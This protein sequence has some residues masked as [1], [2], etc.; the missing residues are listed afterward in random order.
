MSVTAGGGSREGYAVFISYRRR[1]VPSAAVAR[2]LR[3]LLKERGVRTYFDTEEN[4]PGDE[5]SSLIDSVATSPSLRVGVVVIEQ[6]WVAT[7]GQA[8]PE[9]EDIVLREVEHFLQRRAGPEPFVI[10]PIY[11]RKPRLDPGDFPAPP[12]DGSDRVRAVYD[13]LYEIQ[14]LQANA[15]DHHA[16]VVVAADHIRDLV[17]GQGGDGA[18]GRP[19]SLSELAGDDHL[20]TQLFEHARRL[21]VGFPDLRVYTILGQQALLNQD[22]D[23]ARRYLSAAWSRAHADFDSGSRSLRHHLRR[24]VW[25]TH[26]GNMLAIAV[27]GGERPRRLALRAA[28]DLWRDTLSP[29]AG[30]LAGSV[31]ALGRPVDDERASSIDHVAAISLALVH[32]VHEDFFTA[33]HLGFGKSTPAEL[34]ALARSTQILDQHLPPE[35]SDETRN[36][37]TFLKR[38]FLEGLPESDARDD[39][40]PLPYSALRLPF[41][42]DPENP[43]VPKDPQ[44]PWSSPT[45]ASAAEAAVVESGERR[46]GVM[47]TKVYDG[48]PHKR[49]HRE[50]LFRRGVPLEIEPPRR[51]LARITVVVSVALIAWNLPLMGDTSYAALLIVGLLG[52][53]AWGIATA[54]HKED[55]AFRAVPVEIYDRS[56][57]GAA[58]RSQEDALHRLGWDQNEDI[59]AQ[60]HFAIPL[61]QFV[62]EVTPAGHAL[63]EHPTLRLA[64]HIDEQAPRQKRYRFSAYEFHHVYAK[65]RWLGYVRSRYDFIESY[66]AKAEHIDYE[67]W[68]LSDIVSLRVTSTAFVVRTV[69]GETAVIPLAIKSEDDND[70]DDVGDIGDVGDVDAG[71]TSPPAGEAEAALREFESFENQVAE[72]RVERAKRFVNMVRILSDED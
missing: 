37:L 50:S 55:R 20:R 8:E 34:L 49:R 7:L 26:A 2:N 14:A 64:V 11:V 66:P 31:E 53:L 40:R 35:L 44:D 16:A 62:T 25:M 41:A 19:R 68:R 3:D 65:H 56:F 4:R 58:R 23:T 15:F 28:T 61:F 71:A 67:Q 29:T 48:D 38:H 39:V 69:D 27:M 10:Y 1:L 46:Y 43:Q 42:Q 17:H 52:T 6:E 59:Y 36:E 12:S 5:W 47:L 22:F 72:E 54:L 33:R 57:D 51:M 18:L 9:G 24:L 32:F 60:E 30:A 21:D 63:A 13:G 45:G 70:G